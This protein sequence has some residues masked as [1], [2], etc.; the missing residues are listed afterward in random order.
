[1][2]GG[3]ILVYKEKSLTKISVLSGQLIEGIVI[4]NYAPCEGQGH[5]W[6]H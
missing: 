5:K 3:K 6:P 4:N 2:S 1:M